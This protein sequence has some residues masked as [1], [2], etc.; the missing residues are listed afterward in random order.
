MIKV[1]F[2]YVDQKFTYLKVKGHAASAEYGHDLICAG[3]SSIVIGALNNIDAKNYDINIQEG[4][5]I[6]QI[7]NEITTH[8]EIVFETMYI[9]LKTI[10][11]SYPS[12]IKIIK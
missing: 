3:V 10:E 2:K 9:Q 6:V 7:K 8:D 11:E 1:E 12:N 4:L 5:V